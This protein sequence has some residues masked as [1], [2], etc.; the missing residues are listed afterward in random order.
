MTEFNKAYYD[1]IDNKKNINYMKKAI[2][3]SNISKGGPF[4]C[5]IVKNNEVI[6]EAFNT[7]TV[8]NDPTAH[9]EVNAIRKACKKINNFDLSGCILYTSC[10]PCPMCLSAIYWSRINKVYYA[11]TR[12]DAANIGFSDNFIYEE[13]SKNNNEKDIELIKID[14]TDAINTF[15][16]WD[17]NNEKIKY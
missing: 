16:N 7:V 5:I 14:N 8:D 1:L 10:E 11:N 9:A 15:N 6:S 13:L 12:L 3:N 2:Y 17:K 4:G